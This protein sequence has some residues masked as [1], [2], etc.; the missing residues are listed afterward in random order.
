MLSLERIVQVHQITQSMS[1]TRRK[2]I[3]SY[4]ETNRSNKHD[5]N[6]V[7]KALSELPVPVVPIGD[8]HS[9]QSSGN[10]RS[11]EPLQFVQSHMLFQRYGEL[12]CVRL[13][14]LPVRVIRQYL[15]MQV[16]WRMSLPH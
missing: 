12:L 7:A 14:N 1:N 10:G 8:G 16:L 2:K 3:E 9:G 13:G 4:F 11:A 5:L 6:S 15:F